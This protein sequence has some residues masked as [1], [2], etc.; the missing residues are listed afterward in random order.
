MKD[1][2]A[3]QDGSDPGAQIWRQLIVDPWVGRSQTVL[4]QDGW[5]SGITVASYARQAAIVAVIE[6]LLKR[7][8]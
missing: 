7:P 4:R 3:T 2:R 1:N 5:G 8:A 6:L